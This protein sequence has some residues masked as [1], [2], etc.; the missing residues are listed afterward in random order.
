MARSGSIRLHHKGT[1]LWALASH[2]QKPQ[3]CVF[4]QTQAAQKREKKEKSKAAKVKAATAKTA[5]KETRSPTAKS[6]VA[7]AVPEA[8]S[9][10]KK[11]KALASEE[12]PAKVLLP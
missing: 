8:P 4:Y 12:K 5:K 9:S 3:Y 11:R 10:S 2:A 6:E 7:K 1:R